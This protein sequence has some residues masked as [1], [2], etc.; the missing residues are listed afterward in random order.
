[1]SGKA[2]LLLIIGFTVIFAVMGYF[3]GGIATRSVDNHTSYY[4][5]TI[6]HNI[7]VSGANIGLQKVINDSTLTGNLFTEDFENGVMDVDITALGPPVR[8]ITSVGTFMNMEKIVRVKLMRDQ[9]SIAKY[10]WFIPSVSTASV[11]RPWI[12]G[13]TVY[14]GFHSNQFLVVDGDPVFTGRVT[15][16]KGIK[17]QAKKPNVSNPEFLGGYSE[18]IEVDWSSSMHFPNYDALATQPNVNNFDKV[19][20]W[21]KFN[22]DGTVTYASA[23]NGGND[24]TKYPARTTVPVPEMAPNN[25]IYL[26]GGNIYLSG[27]LNG[28]VTVVA[29][30][31]SG[32]GSGNVF[33]V[34]DMIYETD[35]MIPNGAGGFMS[36]PDSDDI[37]GIIAT[38]NIIVSTSNAAN[39]LGGY[40][41]NVANPDIRIDAG[42]FCVKGGFE[43]ENLNSM[44]GPAGS[45]YLQGSMTAGK[46][47]IVA[48]FSGNTITKGYNRHVI[49]DS[50]FATSPPIWFPYLD[51]YRA[52]SWLE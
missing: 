37:M 7:A 42:I 23:K 25:V 29:E 8:T 34:G 10:A 20:L 31:S 13:D 2:S 43:V 27:V 4:K 17:D 26:N 21:L 35:P 44:S 1:M 48:Q 45:I 3:W 36:N 18:G 30:G 12:T 22:S 16:L 51:Y 6:A 19:D 47:E 32:G 50:R 14:G 52:F 49:F 33:L 28:E 41:N 39:N 40:Q 38:N 9:T 15:T 11:N 24:S 46:E 5:S